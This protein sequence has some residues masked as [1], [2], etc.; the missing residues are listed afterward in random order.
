MENEL[1]EM[2]STSVSVMREPAKVLAE[3]KKAAEAL[4]T[5]V[6]QKAKPV[7][8][9]GEQYLEFEDW[10][11][12]ARFYGLTAKVVK[13][14]LIDI[15]G[16]QGYEA[17]AEA[18]RASDGMVISSADSMCLNDEDKWSSRTKYEYENILDEQGKKIWVNGTNGKKGYYKSKRTEVGSVPVPLFQ[19]RSMAQT[20]ACAKV[21]RNVL[22]WVVVLAGFKPSVAEEMTGDEE[23]QGQAA[24]SKPDV[25]MPKEKS[26]EAPKEG[27]KIS[28]KQAKRLYAIARGAGMDE[29][30]FKEWLFFN[31]EYER[32]DA[33]LKSSYEVICTAA[34][35]WKPKA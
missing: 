15:G 20:R 25:G 19:L 16:V 8:I 34:E 1:I 22:A 17:T 33:I 13:T 7:M 29:E 6:K 27:A 4:M 26:G 21:L 28:E 18:V 9:N 14:E 35:A 2:P 30:N 24:S 31:Y 32:T 23:E 5:V 11:T 12:V 3:A 10:Q